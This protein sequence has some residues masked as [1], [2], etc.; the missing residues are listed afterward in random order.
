[1]KKINI[2]IDGYSSCGKSTMAKALANYAGYVYVDTGA[3]YRAVAYYAITNGLIKGDKIDE[4]KLKKEL[5]NITISFKKD[6]AGK[7]DTYLNGVNVESDIRS[8][9]VGNAASKISTIGLVRETLVKQ[10]QKMGEERGVVMDGRDIGTVVFPDAELKIFLTATPKVR[11][12]RRYKELVA[13]GE[14]DVSYQ[15]VLQNVEER[16][17]RDINRKESPLRQADDAVLL[18]NS[19]LTLDEQ[20]QKVRKMFDEKT[21]S[22]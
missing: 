7:Q 21:K 13:K 2:A 15:A 16:D 6:E 22:C 11:A 9:E 5:P 19:N 12:E 17:N 8:L 14:K 1:M 10:Q 3:M 4:E 18:D 20:Q